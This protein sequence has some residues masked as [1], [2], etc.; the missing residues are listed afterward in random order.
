MDTISLDLPNYYKMKL[1]LF[2][3][4]ITKY[5]KMHMENYQYDRSMY[6]C[7]IIP[8]IIMST[9]TGSANIII[10]YIPD[11]YQNSYIFVLGL[12]NIFTSLIT[13]ILEHIRSSKVVIEQKF[14]LIELDKLQAK[15]EFLLGKIV[16]GKVEDMDLKIML[17]IEKKLHEIKEF[18]P[19]IPKFIQK[20]YN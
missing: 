8:L 9:F 16:F 7:T 11:Q 3:D 13:V 20:K 19:E 17:D 6:V 2:I 14:F 10:S 12:I 15:S 18:A 1:D 5:K 4:K